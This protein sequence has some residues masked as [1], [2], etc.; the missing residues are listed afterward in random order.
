MIHDPANDGVA[1]DTETVAINASPLIT[2]DQIFVVSGADEV[3][4]FDHAGTPRWTAKLDGS[5]A[6]QLTSLSDPSSPWYDG[7][8]AIA[9]GLAF[10]P[11]NPNQFVAG[12]ETN[13]EGDYKSVMV[14]LE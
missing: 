5:D 11:A 14:T 9:G 12:I 4:A 1:H 7:F 6:R 8:P 13:Y 3:T 10:N 2:N